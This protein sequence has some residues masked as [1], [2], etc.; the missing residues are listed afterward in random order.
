[1]EP[2]LTVFDGLANLER[3]GEK[4][5]I[6]EGEYSDNNIAFDTA[7]NAFINLL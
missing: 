4:S 2:H 7:C 5:E 1:M 3:K 6:A